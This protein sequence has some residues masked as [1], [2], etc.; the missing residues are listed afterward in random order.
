MPLG[1]GYSVEEQVTGKAEHGGLQIVVHP[2]AREAYDRL[3]RHPDMVTGAFLADMPMLSRASAREMGLAPGGRMRQHIYKD[4]HHLEDWDQDRQG[5]CFVH[6]ANSLTWRQ[7]TGSQPPTV[8]PTAREYAAAHLPWF[9]YYG[10]GEAV[11]GSSILKKLKSV[12]QLGHEKGDVPLPENESVSDLPVVELRQGLGKDQV[13][14][15]RF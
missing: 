8:P 13:R 1:A 14:E 5:R 15:G 9:D 6:L 12:V 4:Q 7:I 10:A 3:H 2:M 11:E